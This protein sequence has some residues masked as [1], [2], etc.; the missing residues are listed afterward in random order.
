MRY[1]IDGYNLLFAWGMTP[2]RDRPGRLGG[3]R[4]NLL[5]RLRFAGA[6]ARGDITVVFDGQRAPRGAPAARDYHGLHVRYSQD[7]TADDLIEE[8]LRHTPDVR[9]L[10]VVSDDHR[11]RDAGRRRQCHVL[12]CLDY[13]ESLQHRAPSPAPPAARDK[14]AKPDAPSA[15]E[16]RRLLEAFGEA[17]GQEP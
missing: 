15:D 16:V 2:P 6:L 1:L 7:G 17:D 4:R 9:H 11:L 14:T 13:I 3:A 8:A 12:R 10:T 5:D